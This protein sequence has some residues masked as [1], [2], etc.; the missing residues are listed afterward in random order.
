MV[1]SQIRS[2]SSR[3][4]LGLSTATFLFLVILL[5]L[6]GCERRDW[7]QSQTE[8]AARQATM[9]ES[10]ETTAEPDAH[11]RDASVPTNPAG[12]FSDANSKSS[13]RVENQKSESVVAEASANEAV[14]LQVVS[15]NQQNE[16]AGTAASAGSTFLI[17]DTRWENTHPKQKVSK[18]KLEGKTDRTMGV[19]GLGSSGG[20]SKPVEYVEMDVAY[21]VPKLSDHVYALVDGQAVA[22]HPV[23]AKLPGGSKPD[24]SFGIAKL[25]EVKELQLAY[26]I[27]ENAKNIALQF[28]DY[29]NGH[30]LIPLQ[31]D[32]EPAKNS[33]DA[34][35][36]VLD[37]ISTDV[38]ELAAQ[39][40]EFANEYQGKAAGPGW[41]YA[42][43]QLGGQSVAGRDGG[44]GKIL[45]FDPTKYTWVNTDGGFIYYASAGS[46]DAKGNI[47]FTPEIFQQQEVA[48]RVPDSAEH[49]SM[50]L[51]I[52]RD[53]VTLS[54]TDRAPE[55]MPNANMRH[56]D[57]D[58]MEILF[59]G[60][61]RDGD[62]LIFDLAIKSITEG[63]GLEVRTARQFLLLTPDG[64]L[65]PDLQATAALAGHPPIPF[66]VPPDSSVRFELA[67]RTAA[68]PTA[69]R[70]RGFRSEGKFDL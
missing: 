61:R 52:N 67:Y 24:A 58:V 12:Q 60:T 35:R 11:S 9:E 49:L 64:E 21:R 59:Y 48:F 57:G 14:S 4:V 45:Q 13:A 54:L 28:F 19:G 16:L 62:Y 38:V 69:L 36:D 51:R 10:A 6:A 5:E 33:K 3:C 43:V 27:P 20:S 8:Q 26:L 25:G 18:D 42:V 53:V 70:L 30:L 34:R 66:V 47:R 39:R 32:A 55:A 17:V 56:Q 29:S 44:M 37:E 63:Q 2:Q 41:R 1:N 46:T 65:K 40:L 15:S 50:G 7:Q 23:T 31:G 68:T 22:L